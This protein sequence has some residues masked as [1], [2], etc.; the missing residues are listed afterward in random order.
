ML[1]PTRFER[2][3]PSYH[4]RWVDHD[5]FYFHREENMRRSRYVLEDHL[6]SLNDQIGSMEPKPS[7]FTIQ[8]KE[9]HLTNVSSLTNSAKDNNHIFIEYWCEFEWEDEKDENQQREEA[10]EKIEHVALKEDEIKNED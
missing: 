10:R 1:Y 8:F 3:E 2:I 7:L 4:T 6:D 9:Q 5:V